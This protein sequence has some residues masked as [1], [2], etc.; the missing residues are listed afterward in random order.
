M[1]D[2]LYERD[3]DALVKLNPET[4]QEL[5]VNDGDWVYIETEKGKITQ[6][7]SV[8]PEL[9]PRVVMAAWGWWFPEEGPDTMYGWRKSNYNILT[10][11][12]DP[13]QP[14]GAPDLKGLPCRVHKA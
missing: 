1:I 12:E 6:K 4:A 7:L 5:G 13:G 2:K 3:P 8:D 9:D 14:V 11:Y 10:G